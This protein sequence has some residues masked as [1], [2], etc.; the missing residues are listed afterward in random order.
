MVIG[1]TGGVGTGKS[2]ILGILNREYDAHVIEADKV[3]HEVMSKNTDAY[4][5]IISI[6]GKGILNPDESINRKLLGNIV[7]NDPKKLEEL[8][9]IIHPAVRREIEDRIARIKAASPEALIVVEAALLIEAGYRDICDQFWYVYS[10]F[11]VRKRRL[12]ESRNYTEDKIEEIA[13]NQLSDDEFRAASDFVIDN[14][15]DID[16]T[17]KQVQEILKT[18]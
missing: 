12:M 10:D 15:H 1:L 16:E 7:F 2:M 14:S 17:R 9:G 3:G 4:R 6:F 13:E 18:F 8:N 5:Q 11:D